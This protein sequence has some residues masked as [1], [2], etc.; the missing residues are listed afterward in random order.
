MI[1]NL[2]TLDLK[3]PVKSIK[4]QKHCFKHN[5]NYILTYYL[6]PISGKWVTNDRGCA[7]CG[8]NVQIASRTA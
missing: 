6:S 2:S 1:N 8:N 5:L 3:T 4:E 7:K